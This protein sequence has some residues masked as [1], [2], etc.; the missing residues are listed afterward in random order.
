MPRTIYL[1]KKSLLHAKSAYEILTNLKNFGV[2]RYLLRDSL[3]KE[4]PEPS[5]YVVRHVEPQMD[6]K[7]LYGRIWVEEVLRGWKYPKIR[8]ITPWL[9]DYKLIAKHE[10]PDLSKFPVL[11]V[12]K[13]NVATLPKNYSVPPVMAEYFNRK[14][15]GFFPNIYLKGLNKVKHGYDAESLI[16]FT[17]PRK[18]P[19]ESDPEEFE[20][21]FRIAD[22]DSGE[23]PTLE[24][25]KFIHDRFLTGVQST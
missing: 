3:C 1:G 18:Y 21:R 6:E 15:L 9:H 25:K 19:E 10:E 5:F 14:K 7:L 22:E 8:E 17:V 2:G 20:Y 24:M 4:H 11:G 16:K 23:K 12:D 13:S